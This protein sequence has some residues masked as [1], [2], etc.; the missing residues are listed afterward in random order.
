MPHRSRPP[1]AAGVPGGGR[2]VTRAPSWR[3]VAAAGLIPLA[4][5]DSERLVEVQ[6]HPAPALFATARPA[7]A[8]DP[9]HCHDGLHPAA[10]TGVTR[11]SGTPSH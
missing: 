6:G 1:G 10:D 2:A 4:G 9:A 5:G 11:K 8:G 3:A 7:A